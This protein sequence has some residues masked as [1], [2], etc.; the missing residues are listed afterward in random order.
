MVSQTI[1]APSKHQ[2]SSP[3][4]C[5]PV[6][7][8]HVF[9]S[10]FCEFA[11]CLRIGSQDRATGKSLVERIAPSGLLRLE[12]WSKG[13]SSK[14]RSLCE[15]YAKPMRSLCE[16]YAKPMRSLCE[17]RTVASLGGK[18]LR[19]RP[20]LSSLTERS[21]GLDFE[22]CGACRRLQCCKSSKLNH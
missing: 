12:E 17:A 21:P 19:L 3:D 16:A 11:G 2:L 4:P 15:A 18:G 8:A 9:S 20:T 10:H 6:L 1:G 14:M 5:A 13:S 22:D 7:L